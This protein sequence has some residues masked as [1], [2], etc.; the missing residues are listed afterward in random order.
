MSTTSKQKQYGSCEDNCGN[1]GIKTPPAT[2]YDPLT[3]DEGV[4]PLFWEL[5]RR[6]PGFRFRHRQ[7]DSLLK[8]ERLQF[9][10]SQKAKLAPGQPRCTETSPRTEAIPELGMRAR[11]RNPQD[12]VLRYFFRL[13]TW[14][15]LA[16]LV[17]AWSFRGKPFAFRWPTPDA[18]GGIG[19]TDS[20][21]GRSL[22]V[23]QLTQSSAKWTELYAEAVKGA[24][25]DGTKN[26]QGPGPGSFIL[27]T[28]WKELPIRFRAYFS[29]LAEEYDHRL[30]WSREQVVGPDGYGGCP[31]PGLYDPNVDWT[32]ISEALD[33]PLDSPH[34]PPFVPESELQA[35]AD[36]CK[37]NY[38]FLIPKQLTSKVEVN[39]LKSSFNAALDRLFADEH[40][41]A[42]GSND[43]T[44]YGASTDWKVLDYC[45]ARIEY[46]RDAQQALGV[47]SRNISTG[48]QRFYPRKRDA[49]KDL[50]N[51]IAAEGKTTSHRQSDFKKR[52]SRMEAEMMMTFPRFSLKP[53][54]VE[55]L[56]LDPEAVHTFSE[57]A[58]LGAGLKLYHLIVA[59]MS[60]YDRDQA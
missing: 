60:D 12:L 33:H 39:E 29:W 31:P 13:A 4:G 11:F 23:R 50:E 53:C 51:E 17:M 8:G 40:G 30:N 54:L 3:A 45:R 58:R 34:P 2:D 48:Y 52:Y 10:A 26:T 59:P 22:Q 16:A 55:H 14:N 25:D 24:A 28:A 18:W 9:I 42:V 32:F 20:D 21:L 7:L 36:T 57:R 46:T 49:F 27:D 56:E 38:L 47:E 15:P 19:L 44:P 43:R 41:I 1:V 35:L 37:A 5:L 6:H